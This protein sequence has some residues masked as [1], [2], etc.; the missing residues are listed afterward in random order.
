MEGKDG[1]GNGRKRGA[2]TWIREKLVGRKR[3]LVLSVVVGALSGLMAYLLKSLIE[4]IHVTVM[5]GAEDGAFNWSYLVY[6]SV[7]IL[8]TALFIRYVVRDDI[9]HG[10]TKI[11][12]AIAR[13]QGHIRRHN[14]WSSVAASSVTIGMGGSVGAESPAVLTGA[15]IGSTLGEWFKVDQKTLFILIGCGATGAVAGIFKAPFAGLLFTLEVLMID[16]TMA[17]LMPLLLSSVT[18]TLVTFCFTGQET[19]FS[20]DEEMVFTLGSVVPTVWLGVGCGVVAIY[21]TWMAGKLEDFFGRMRG[22]VPKFVVG[23]VMLGASILLLP[24]LYGEGYDT[25]QTL[26]NGEGT[27]LL[28]DSF[29]ENQ[30]G[31]LLLM[32]GLIILVKV[33][34][35]TATTSGGGCGG[36]FAPSLFLGCVCG[37]AFGMVW[38]TVGGETTIGL[39]GFALLGMAGMMTGVM[40]SPL[41]S[42][43]LIAELTGGYTLLVPLMVVTT[44]TYLTITVGAANPH[45][46]YA[47]RLAKKGQLVTHNRDKAILTLMSMDG[48]IDRYCMRI[49][50][51]TELG[52]MVMLIGKEKADVFPVVDRGEHLL[53]LIELKELRNVIFRQEL[54]RSFNAQ[55]LMKKPVCVVHKGDAM[56]QVMELFRS[57]NV[58]AIPVLDE[59][60]RFVGMVYKE[61]LYATYQQMQA[62]FAEE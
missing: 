12:F 55:G 21:F 39:A 30:G 1:D 29:F 9:G 46:I 47:R 23:S 56:V 32:L 52:R 19:M 28:R 37:Y 5:P 17:S 6:P 24:P 8:I 3:L 53:G 25:I 22:L 31:G 40:H 26:I 45:S 11:L 14:C 2:W 59:S 20:L 41:T 51:E 7:G 49:A 34:A 35:T 13:R 16:L 44:V 33:F 48:V 38:G 62:D 58:E 42:I 57:K 60:E 43:F 18:A 15:A 4:L 27:D 54:Y 36:L 10:V 50:P 61:K